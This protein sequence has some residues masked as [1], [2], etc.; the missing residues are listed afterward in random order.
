VSIARIEHAE[1]LLDAPRHNLAELAESLGHVAAINRWLGGVA[2]IL[3]HVRP[4]LRAGR[5]VRILDVATGSADIPV[6]IAEL[7]R[8]RGCHVEIVATDVHP[9]MRELAR[10]RCHAHPEIT[11]QSADA[12]QLPYAARSFHAALLS[13]ALHH[14]E[15]R[16]QLRVL[17]EMSRVS[18]EVVL[19]NDLARTRLNYLGARLLGATY[20]RR[21][22]LTRHDGPLSVLRSL[23][24]RELQDLAQKAGLHGRVHRHFFQRLVLEV[25][26]RY[27]QHI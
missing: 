18:S 1:E 25:D 17:Q 20:W 12:L 26:V 24:R 4:L 15:G 13:L 3:K 9:Q 21:N 19:V 11:V 5:N 7:A 14:F 27:P 10:L 23:T 16:E 6:A 22:R 8:R 2:A